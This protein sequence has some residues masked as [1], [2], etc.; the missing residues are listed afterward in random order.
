MISYTEGEDTNFWR[1][2]ND[3]T[4]QKAIQEEVKKL[5]PDRDIPDPI[6]LKKHDWEQGCTYWK[7]GNYNID[8]ALLEAQNPANNL[9]IC[10]ESVSKHQSWVE[11][12]LESAEQLML[13][14]RGL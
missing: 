5:F 8:E 7:K 14:N 9:Y 6:Y 2:K 13:A 12:A 11:S 10:G 4:L 1:H 3:E